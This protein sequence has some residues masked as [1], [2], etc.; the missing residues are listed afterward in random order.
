MDKSMLRA[1]CIHLRLISG[2]KGLYFK[3][4][5]SDELIGNEKMESEE[6]SFKKTFILTVKENG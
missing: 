5:V 3:L 6:S 2:A 1:R 4:A